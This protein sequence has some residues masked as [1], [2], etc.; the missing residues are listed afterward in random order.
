MN[1]PLDLR[2]TPFMKN[3]SPAPAPSEPMPTDLTAAELA[4][5]FAKADL[6]RLKGSGQYARLR[7][8]SLLALVAKGT[9]PNPYATAITRL[10]G[11][12]ETPKTDEEKIDLLKRNA[13]AFMGVAEL[14][15]VEPRIVSDRAPNYA[16]GE[17]AA[18]DLTDQDLLW[19]FYEFSQEVDSAV[20]PFRVH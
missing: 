17:I 4:Q 14:C 10:L 9:I 8:P 11:V 15:F 2:N 13:T 19:L 16:A 7:R 1:R 18:E 20:A 5:R 12:T 3:T 6:Y